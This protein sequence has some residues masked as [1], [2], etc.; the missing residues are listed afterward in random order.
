MQLTEENLCSRMA[1]KSA[2]GSMKTYSRNLGFGDFCYIKIKGPEN[3][4]I[5]EKRKKIKDVPHPSAARTEKLLS[6]VTLVKQ[7]FVISV[8]RSAIRKYPKCFEN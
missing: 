8:I 7:R 5:K 2:H 6:D 3:L 1:L 4:L